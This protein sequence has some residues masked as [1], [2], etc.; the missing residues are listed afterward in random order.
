MATNLVFNQYSNLN[1]VGSKVSN[2]GL[3]VKTPIIMN[4]LSK[5]WLNH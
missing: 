4:S 2:V 5:S 1:S 3:I